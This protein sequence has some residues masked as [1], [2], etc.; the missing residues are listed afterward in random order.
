MVSSLQSKSM[1]WFIE[2]VIWC[3]KG[4]KLDIDMWRKFIMIYLKTTSRMHSNVNT[5]YIFIQFVEVQF[6]CDWQGHVIVQCAYKRTA[7]EC[8]KFFS[9]N[10]LALIVQHF[11]PLPDLLLLLLMEGNIQLNSNR[12]LWFSVPHVR[13][14]LF[15]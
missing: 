1:L 8:Q 3:N 10:C 6:A 9:L 13:I 7:L 15:R 5:L 4:L 12:K 11:N 14:I 2:A